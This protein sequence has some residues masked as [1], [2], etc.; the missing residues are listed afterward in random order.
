MIDETVSAW[1]SRSEVRESLDRWL[2]DTG[3]RLEAIATH[4]DVDEAVREAALNDPANEQGAQGL[5]AVAS[6]AARGG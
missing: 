4:A 1:T 6:A 5:M 3:V 2:D